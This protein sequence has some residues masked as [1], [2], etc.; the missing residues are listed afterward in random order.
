M[1]FARFAWRVVAAHT[2]TYMV[3]GLLASTLLD[4]EAWWT[5]EW[6]AHYRPMHS[7]WVA[8]GPA[9][10]VVRGL[11]LAAVLWPFRDTFLRGAR[12][13]LQLWALLVGVGILSTYG[14]GPGSIEGVVYTALPPAYHVF[15]LPEVYG[16]ALAF[17][18]ILVGW[19]RWPHR[20]WDV[21]LGLGTGLTV[22]MSLAGVFLAPLAPA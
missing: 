6:M 13:A 14:A 5:T 10:Q 20:A 12:G 19:C 22:L 9:L 3:A 21:V 11:L 18:G 8:A 17:S 16:Q 1:T 4:Y 15:G 7:P 2:T